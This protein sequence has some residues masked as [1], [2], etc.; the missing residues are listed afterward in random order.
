MSLHFPPLT[1]FQLKNRMRL[2]CSYPVCL[3]AAQPSGFLLDHSSRDPHTS[4][5]EWPVQHALCTASRSLQQKQAGLKPGLASIQTFSRSQLGR[6]GPGILSAESLPVS[7]SVPSSISRVREG[8]WCRRY[9]GSHH[10]A[11][12]TGSS[13]I[14][15]RDDGRN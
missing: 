8:E 10:L 15:F 4:C 12:L 14:S 2:F 6:S 7:F 9:R 11:A 1:F 13:E 5:S 3:E